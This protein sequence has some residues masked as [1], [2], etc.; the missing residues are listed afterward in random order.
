MPGKL[1]TTESDKATPK[2]IVIYRG[3]VGGSVRGLMHEWRSVFLPWSSKKLH[4]QNRSL[5][6][7]IS[8]ASI[9]SVSHLQLFTSPRNGASLRIMRFSN[10]PTLSFRVES[11]TLRNE[12]LENQRRPVQLGHECFDVAPIVVLN[13]FNLPSN[14][15]VVALM[16]ATFKSLF[17][18][19]NIQFIKTS[20]IQRAV[21]FHYDPE[22][23]LVE[24]RHYFIHSKAVGISKSV[25]KLLEGRL[26]TKL[27]TL[28]N[29]NDILEKEGAWSDTDGE[30]EEIALPRPFRQHKEQ[31]RIK[32]QE[33]GPRMTLSLT[34]VENGF[35]GG[36]VIFHSL[37]EKTSK[38]VAVNA[39]RVRAKRNE[40]ARRR[41]EQQQNVLRK[42]ERL[43]SKKE[44]KKQR[45]EDIAKR[46]AEHP[47][48][49]AK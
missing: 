10:G 20:D 4:G 38:E 48:D 26:P 31:C 29:I 14:P 43:Q 19:I 49:V 42:K 34:K 37:V 7:F 23:Q 36:E 35:A 41:G 45:M 32:L 9:F 21:L 1:D 6:D 24:A 16:E 30:G 11:F 8:V 5:K 33:I 15:P 46:Q 12:I 2:S 39:H 27:G 28:D 44:K 40:K 25:K 18:T 17:P 13:N 22:T 3:D 47:F